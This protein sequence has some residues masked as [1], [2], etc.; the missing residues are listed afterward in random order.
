MKVLKT[1]FW[2]VTVIICLTI[3]AGNFAEFQLNSYEDVTPTELLVLQKLEGEELD[4][5]TGDYSLVDTDR[6]DY[7]LVAGT[8]Y[9]NYATNSLFNP[10]GT[11][12]TDV[13]YG[14]CEVIDSIFSAWQQYDPY[15]AEI[16]AGE[17]MSIMMV[18]EVEPEATAILSWDNDFLRA[19]LTK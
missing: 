16:P 14:D 19:D 9:N 2:T 12:Y 1:V 13:E 5:C 11:F 17:M 15:Y 18:M 3:V 4:I 6:Y 8:F 10:N 7:Y